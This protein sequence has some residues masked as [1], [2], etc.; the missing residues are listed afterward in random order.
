MSSSAF[1]RAAQRAVLWCLLIAAPVYSV[2][3]SVAQVIG[4][5]HARRAAVHSDEPLR[6]WHEVLRAIGHGVSNEQIHRSNFE[7]HCQMPAPVVL[8][9]LEVRAFD[10]LGDDSFDANSFFGLALVPPAL[11]T[12][13]TATSTPPRHRHAIVALTGEGSRLDRPPKA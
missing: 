3:S 9:V 13:L 10:S 5:Q 7:R 8:A 4:P 12:A 11:I 2:S 1:A 6:G